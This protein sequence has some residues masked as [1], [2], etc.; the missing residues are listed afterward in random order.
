MYK[1]MIV[2]DEPTIRA[3]LKQYFP[4]SEL[5]VN[6]I[7][8]AENGKEGITIA[9]RERPDLVITDIRMPEVDGLE[10]IEQLR[11]A[12]PDTVFVLLTGYNDFAYAQKAIRIGGIQSYLLKPLEYDESLASLLECLKVLEI[13]RQEQQSRSELEQ[14]AKEAMTLLHSQF[15]KHLLEDQA[16]LQPDMLQRLCGFES[17]NYMFYSIVVSNIPRPDSIPGTNMHWKQLA[18]RL[19]SDVATTLL[20]HDNRRQILMYYHKSKLYTLTIFECPNGT[21]FDTQI[22]EQVQTLLNQ[23]NLLELPAT[24][25]MAMGQPMSQ[26]SAAG[27]SLQLVDKALYK[28]FSQPGRYLFLEQGLQ[29]SSDVHKEVASHLVLLESHLILEGLEKGDGTLTRKLMNQ[30]ADESRMKLPNVSS[31]EWLAFLQEII[32]VTLRFA[33]KHG[34]AVEGVYSNKLLTLT[35]VD[36]FQTIDHLFDWLFEWIIHLNTVYQQQNQLSVPKD[37]LIF[38]QI[39]NFIE[40][41]IDQELTLQMVADRFF[42]N[43]SYLSRLFKTKLN[44]NYMTFVTEIRIHYAQQCL[45]DPKYLVTDV[46]NMCGYKS[47]KHFVKMFRSVTQMTPSDYRKQLGW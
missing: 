12:L 37:V 3:G 24:M 26:L 17:K 29:P 16:E 4:W 6:T 23:L 10:M 27:R 30:L 14:E 39:K 21:R 9:L 11:T 31:D 2:E 45:K 13:R 19:V 38:E 22:E 25:Y 7:V 42:Y 28:R 34:I 35:F 44:K 46:C 5:G 32:N 47:Y 41:H 8:E 36:D 1:L 43:P 33:H 15:L 40:H 20:S 18:E